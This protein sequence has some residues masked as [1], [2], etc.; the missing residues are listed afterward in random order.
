MTPK[1]FT[2]TK[3][4]ECPQFCNKKIDAMGMCYDSKTSCYNIIYPECLKK[5]HRYMD[6][7]YKGLVNT[8]RAT[9][10]KE[11][12]FLRRK[13]NYQKYRRAYDNNNLVSIKKASFFYN[14]DTIR[15]AIE[16]KEIE[17]YE[18]QRE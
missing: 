1:E 7:D 12:L 10:I 18:Q 13:E 16:L 4:S 14:R 9:F 11:K 6:Y 3:K 17:F 8:K 15:D 2:V 5:C